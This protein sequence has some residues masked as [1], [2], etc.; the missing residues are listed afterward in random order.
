M[1]LLIIITT[2]DFPNTIKCIINNTLPAYQDAK[3][4]VRNIAVK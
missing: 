4:F 2:L 1:Q 3:Y